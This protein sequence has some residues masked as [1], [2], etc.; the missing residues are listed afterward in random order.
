MKRQFLAFTLIAFFSLVGA[1][2]PQKLDKESK[3]L[4]GDISAKSMQE[5]LKYIS[6]DELEGRNTPSKGLDLAAD[7]IAADFKKSG[8]EP[9]GDDGYFQTTEYTNRKGE[10]GKVRNVIGVLRGSD[11]VLKDT[12]VLVTAHYDHLGLNAKLTGDQI[13]NGANDDGSGTVSVMELAEAFGKLKVHPKR[14]IVFMTFYGE[15]KGLV[16][17]R[18]YGKHPI[19]PVAQTIADVNLE[20][21][22][23]TDDSEA[24]RVLGASMTGFDYSDIGTI[25]A[26]A[27]KE[28]G[29]AVTKHPQYSDMFFAR[30]DNQ[31][32]ADLGVPAHTICVAF[33]Y[34]DYHRVSDTWD[35]VDYGNMAKVDQM[36]ALGLLKIANSA[37]VPHWNAG[38]PKAARYLTAWQV[39]HPGK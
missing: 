11:P 9:A 24:P 22:G 18:Y 21:I 31:A 6:S 33:E 12:Y 26:D 28:V 37:D 23:R 34:P 19:F 20:Q 10:V 39:S 36:V 13:Y 4:I 1:S 17:S 16:G 30:S 32:L 25:F 7:Y 14:S 29:I 27:G 8:L 3:R 38:N 35:K 2:D 5:H 15:E